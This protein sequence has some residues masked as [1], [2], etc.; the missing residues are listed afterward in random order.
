LLRGRPLPSKGFSLCAEQR[1]QAENEHR[2]EARRK[3][4]R[5]VNI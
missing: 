4:S 2:G 5:T 3:E 1:E